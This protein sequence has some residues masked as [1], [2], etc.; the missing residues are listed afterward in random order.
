MFNRLRATFPHY[1]SKHPSHELRE[2]YLSVGVMDFATSAVALFEPIYLYTRG[3]GIARI[4]LFYAVVYLLYTVLL[5]VG[6]RIAA[7]L[8]F[9][10]AIF[11]SQFFFIGYYL[12]L[13]ALPYA[14]WLI[15]LSPLIFAIQ[16]SLYWPAY[17]ADFAI[18]SAREQRGREV[19]GLLTLNALTTVLGP[20][21]GGLVLNFFGF[22]ALFIIVSILFFVS[23]IPLLKL[24]EVYDPKPFTYQSYWKLLW[25]PSHRRTGVAYWGYGEE[26][27]A[28]TLWPIL[29]FIAV[30]KYSELGAL[31]AISTLITSV[32]AL[33][34][35]KIVDRYSQQSTLKVGAYLQA[36]VWFVRAGMAL[37]PLR[38]V[39]LDAAG[40]TAKNLVV[41]PQ[42][43]MTYEHGMRED[44][45]AIAVFFEQS[46][47]IGKLI[48]A[49]LVIILMQ[50]MAWW[51][52]AFIVAGFAS[53][54]YGRLTPPSVLDAPMQTVA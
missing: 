15:F 10:H 38:L 33:L 11:V 17:H 23:T 18:F 53:F 7:R 48:M 35:G 51:F 43:A 21:F 41:V 39:C 47:A 26:L 14:P 2:L 12:S 28:L 29:T 36:I 19:S 50:F 30:S 45:L 52:A 49:V 9:E 32:V 8:G 6:G 31:I 25:K 3:Y 27:I 34:I 20:I 44:P 4:L 42:M 13:F 5:P 24:Q 46:L 40:R 37:T 1:F 22:G 54:L 16:K